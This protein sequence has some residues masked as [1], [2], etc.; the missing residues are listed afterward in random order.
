MRWLLACADVIGIE[1]AA[2]LMRTP[3]SMGFVSRCRVRVDAA[4]LAAG[5]EEASR[6]R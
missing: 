1:R 3:V 4:L 2:D 5:F 6:M